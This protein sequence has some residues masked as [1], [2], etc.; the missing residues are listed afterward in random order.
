MLYANFA[1]SANENVYL[2]INFF[3]LAIERR[4][5]VLSTIVKWMYIR[6]NKTNGQARDKGKEKCLPNLMMSLQVMSTK[7]LNE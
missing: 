6:K 4:I 1:A 7:M 5:K 2:F 3:L